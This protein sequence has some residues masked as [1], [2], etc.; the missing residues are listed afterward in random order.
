ME[1][2][3]EISMRSANE[4]KD[5]HDLVPKVIEKLFQHF[6]I[7]HTNSFVSTIG[8]IKDI[9]RMKPKFLAFFD[10]TIDPLNFQV[11]KI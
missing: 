8:K 4:L 5:L 6:K 1:F 3:I 10:E 2:V 7:L 9:E 11:S